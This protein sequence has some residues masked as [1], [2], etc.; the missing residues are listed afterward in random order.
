LFLYTKLRFI[1]ISTFEQQS[2]SQELEVAIAYRL[3][4][5]NNSIKA[6]YLKLKINETQ[7]ITNLRPA[8]CAWQHGAGEEKHTS[9][10]MRL[11]VN[12]A[13]GDLMREFSWINW[14]L[15]LS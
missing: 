15:T 10:I 5:N 7:E 14:A 9:K 11:G 1:S 3:P 2:R 12:D 8:P 13:F 4:K 6:S